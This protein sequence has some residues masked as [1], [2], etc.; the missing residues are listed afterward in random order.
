LQVGVSRAVLQLENL[1]DPNNVENITVHTN[2]VAETKATALLVCYWGAD[3]DHL[4][5]VGM[6]QALDNAY[7]REE[8]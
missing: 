3:G 7:G 5:R 4:L 1:R 6:Q 8:Q 2:V